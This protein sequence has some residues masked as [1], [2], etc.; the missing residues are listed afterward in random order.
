MLTVKLGAAIVGVLSLD[1]PEIR[2]S[3]GVD[4]T[5]AG[6]RYVKIT[7]TREALRKLQSECENRTSGAWDQDPGF[8]RSAKAA[9]RK[10]AAALRE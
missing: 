6:R 10:L 9:A 1:E 4:Y 2:Q 3:I 5:S 8:A 7:G